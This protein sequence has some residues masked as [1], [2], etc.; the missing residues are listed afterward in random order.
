MNRGFPP[1]SHPP[2]CRPSWDLRCRQQTGKESNGMGGEAEGKADNEF[3]ED[4]DNERIGIRI[5]TI[6][7][8]KLQTRSGVRD[9][10]MW[11][12]EGLP[13]GNVHRHEPCS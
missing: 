4:R 6:S 5:E 13:N 7:S 8:P 9:Q 12:T 2:R 3:D 11:V 10:R 1:S